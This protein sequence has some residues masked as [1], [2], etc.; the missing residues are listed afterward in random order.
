MARTVVLPAASR[1]IRQKWRMWIET[2]I[3]LLATSSGGDSS[4]RNG[5]CGLKLFAERGIA[6][7]PRFIRQK[8][9][10]WIETMKTRKT[11]S[12][13]PIHPSEMADVD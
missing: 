11:P 2:I 4:V 8:W 5:G 6:R 10:M 9:R 13:L 12:K 1:F 3:P 7:Q